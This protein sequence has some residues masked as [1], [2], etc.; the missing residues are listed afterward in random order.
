M[1]AE[2][3][4][5]THSVARGVEKTFTERQGVVTL[6][7]QRLEK[8]D[9]VSPEGG[10]GRIVALANQT[11]P[12]GS[13]DNNNRREPQSAKFVSH[14]AS[15]IK[16]QRYRDSLFFGK[17]AHAFRRVAAHVAP[18]QNKLNIGVIA[19]AGISGLQLGQLCFA[20]HTPGGKK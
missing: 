20:R 11:N 15:E 10:L 5:S 8:T 19:Q 13:I 2:Q 4:S 17:C 16:C 12:P 9:E 1:L 14:A 18:D 7:L 3:A 6:L